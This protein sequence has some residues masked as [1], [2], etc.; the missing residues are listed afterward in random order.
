MTAAATAT[1]NL[2]HVGVS[3]GYRNR[4]RPAL[5]SHYGV[6][7]SRVEFIECAEYEAESI[8]AARSLRRHGGPIVVTD[9]DIR[10]A[11]WSAW[12]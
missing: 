4:L 8:I 2:V 3:K 11:D 1:R 10:E 12:D 9:L 5:A 7:Q 6:P